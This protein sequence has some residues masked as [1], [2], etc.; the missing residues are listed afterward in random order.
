MKIEAM[1]FVSLITALI[2][3]ASFAQAKD[4][5]LVQFKSEQGF[6]AMKSYFVNTESFKPVM[7]KS[8]ENVHAI[9]LKTTNL[10]LINRLV[11][12]PEV[13]YVEAEF[14]SPSPKPVNGFKIAR[15]NVDLFQRARRQQPI[16][17]GASTAGTSVSTPEFKEGHATP[18]GILAVQ[19]GE[20]WAL[21]G[22][23]SKARVM[24]LD[25]G[26]DEQHPAIAAN[27]EKGKNFT[28]DANGK[29]VDTAY[30]DEEGHGTHVSGT[31]LG[32][33][34]QE[35]GFTGV[36]PK[37]KLLMGRVCGFQGCS[38]IAVVAGIN[39][40]IQE[41]VDV[42]NMSL[43]GPIGSVATE[44]AVTKADEAGLVVVAASG[45]GA[46]DPNYS[47]DKE[48][49][50]CGGA[51]DDF[52]APNMCGVS[53]PAAF[54]T[55]VAVGALNSSLE[56]TDF[57]QWGPELDITAPGAAV[58]SSIPRGAG[59][60]SK[61]ELEVA[62][63]KRVVKSSAFGG[64]VLFSS[65]V[66][67]LLVAIPGVGKPEDFTG[68]DV[69]GKFALISRGE[70]TFFDKVKNAMKAKAAGVVI[71]NN[72]P[73]LM[74]GSL[75]EDGTLLSLPVVIIE[76]TEGA[77]I[78]AELAKGTAVSAAV[79]I[80]PSDY[81][82]FDGTSMAAPH[83]AGVVAL[84]KSANKKLTPAQVRSILAST[85]KPLAPNN[86]NQFGAGIIQADLAV[87][88]AVSQ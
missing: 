32:V 8:L 86:T 68:V 27:F 28:E 82:A 16:K 37:A 58:V 11:N 79:S 4:R 49:N 17:G 1:K 25:T 22:A 50:K 5:Y 35:N 73:G 6:K 52:F 38:N 48:A 57:S 71:Y 19:A 42:I 59:R 85:A 74:Q 64:T 30:Q 44:Q 21:S 40:A 34:N 47:S 45:N 69:A 23:G 76:Q 31:V 18:W 65:P 3:L 43:G 60:E 87:K 80:S 75:S 70:I 33:Y 51:G 62:G 36:A 77:A 2:L 56:K 26:I 24:V 84:I 83:V 15:V 41:K 39:W 88:K 55:V 72:K 9:I 54:P 13:E 63:V 14:F 67:N 7:Q 53:F 20:A 12:H 29:V 81:A 66:V 46:T 10:N 61:V 78:L